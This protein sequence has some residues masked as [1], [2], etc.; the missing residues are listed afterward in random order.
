METITKAERNSHYVSEEVV[1][2]KKSHLK[3]IVDV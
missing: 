1:V 2:E 3:K